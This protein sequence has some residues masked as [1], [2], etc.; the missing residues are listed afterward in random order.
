MKKIRTVIAA[1]L[2]AVPFALNNSSK[3]DI[4]NQDTRVSFVA[5][6]AA[7]NSV[8]QNKRFVVPSILASRDSRTVGTIGNT[9]VSDWT[10]GDIVFEGISDYTGV[11]RQWSANIFRNSDLARRPGT[12]TWKNCFVAPSVNPYNAGMKWGLRGYNVPQCEFVDCDFFAIPKEHGLY[13]SNYEGTLVDNC[14]FVRMGSQGVQFAHRPLDYQQY[15]ADNRPYESKPLHILRDSHFIDCAQGGSRPSY[16]ASYFNP[17]SPA[18]PGTLLVEDCSFVCKWT[19]PVGYY[20]SLSSGA[21]VVTPMQGNDPLSDN[22]MELVYIKNCLFDFTRGNRAIVNIRAT[23]TVIFEDCTFIA[24]DHSQPNLN[25][26]NYTDMMGTAKTQRV[27]I[28]N[29]IGIGGVKLRVYERTPNTS[30]Y[31]EHD[32]NTYGREIV[33]D[34]EDGQMI[35]FGPYN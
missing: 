3:A 29:C 31:V 9:M 12:Y 32:V 8:E 13:I 11:G 16:N 18:F 22:F 5:H 35:S 27:I 1:G 17:G 21:L 15:S 6:R 33:I 30:Q 7:R 10:E 4:T 25:I 19:Q 14:T 26:D 20:Q 34:G 28:R 2:L 23:D 24:R